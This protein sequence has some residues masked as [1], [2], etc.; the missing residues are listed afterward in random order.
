MISIHIK[1][2]EGG[3]RTGALNLCESRQYGLGGGTDGEFSRKRRN[4]VVRCFCPKQ[5]RLQCSVVRLPMLSNF[6][7]KLGFGLSNTSGMCSYN[8][9]FVYT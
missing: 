4:K 8:C 7:F 3:W 1:H 9:N 2:H 6:S 5:M